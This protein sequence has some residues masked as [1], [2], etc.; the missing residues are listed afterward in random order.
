MKTIEIS[1]ASKPLCDYEKEFNEEV[2]VLTSDKKP[3]AAIVSLK[4][5]DKESLSLSTSPEFIE[6]IGKARDEFKKGKKLSF[7]EMKRTFSEKK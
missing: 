7:D 3:I 6:I 1:S 2:I 4:N 5:V